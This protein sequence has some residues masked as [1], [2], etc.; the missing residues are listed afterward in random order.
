M[1]TGLLGLTICLLFP[2]FETNAQGRYETEIT[3]SQWTVSISRAECT[4]GHRVTG[5]GTALFRQPA[6]KALSFTLEPRRREASIKRASLTVSAPTWMHDAP[7]RQQYSVF[8]D[9]SFSTNR[10]QL[11]VG[12]EVAE[13]MLQELKGGWFPLFRY[14]T[15]SEA[16]LVR[17]TEVAVSAVNFA[18]A[19]ESFNDCRENLLPFAF[20]EIR[21]SEL[22]FGSGSSRIDRSMK[23]KI[24]AI[25]EYLKIFPERRLVL[26]SGFGA[27]GGVA[28][29]N[30]NA[31]VSRI[32]ALLAEAGVK[33]GQVSVRPGGAGVEEEQ[34]DLSLVGV[35]SLKTIHYREKSIRLSE[36]DKQKLTL[37]ARYLNGTAS[38]ARITINGYT[39]SSGSIAS[40]KKLSAKRADSVRRFL[41]SQGVDPDRMKLRAWGESR[42]LSSNRSTRGRA[43]NRR[44]SISFTG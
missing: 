1:K 35:E 6:G 39:D 17:E 11:V 37:L 22:L 38:H 16:A 15:S 12:G 42:P 13:L 7:A 40:N 26:S 9:H 32:K 14:A 28:K 21:N 41:L 33:A 23:G 24:E 29:K 44:V 10:Q 36:R 30:F 3:E 34:A 4:M 31:R 27:K 18:A 19:E 25:A 2:V 5:Y 20:D 43:N 8:L